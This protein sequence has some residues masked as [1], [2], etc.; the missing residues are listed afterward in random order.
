MYQVPGTYERNGGREWWEGDECIVR[1]EGVP[2]LFTGADDIKRCRLVDNN[3]NDTF[4]ESTKA[5]NY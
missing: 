2:I 5:L 3:S 1:V 4:E